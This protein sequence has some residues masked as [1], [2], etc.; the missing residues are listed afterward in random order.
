MVASP[1]QLDEFSSESGVVVSAAVVVGG[2]GGGGKI[3]TTSQWSCGDKRRRPPV[4][5]R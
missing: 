5:G 2:G 3:D 1:C 4:S